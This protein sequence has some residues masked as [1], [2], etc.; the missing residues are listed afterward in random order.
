MEA[1][2]TIKLGNHTIYVHIDENPPNPRTEWDNLG[3]MVCFHNRYTLGDK[4][5]G[6]NSNDFANWDELQ[7]AIK[8]DNDVAAILPIYMYDHSGLTINTTG[9]SCPWDSGQIGFIY[10]TKE[11][12]RKEFSAKRVSGKLSKKMREYLKGEVESYD[13]YLRGEYYGFIIENDNGDVVDSCWGFDDKDYMIMEAKGYIP[14]DGCSK[15]VVPS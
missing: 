12:V 11:Q 13:K 4:D 8:K 15:S 9:F 1:I 3:T 14:C 6:Y 7:A 2:E 10:I 5:H